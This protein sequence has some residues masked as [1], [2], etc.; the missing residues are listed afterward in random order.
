MSTSMVHAVSIQPT[1]FDRVLIEARIW[2]DDIVPDRYDYYIS[3]GFVTLPA[4]EV[5]ALAP[6]NQ[7]YLVVVDTLPGTGWN[8]PCKLVYVN[9]LM[10]YSDKGQL[11]INT[12]VKDAK[13]PPEGISM[14]P[15]SVKDRYS[16]KLLPMLNIKSGQ[17]NN[18]AS[19]TYAVILNTSP[20]PWANAKQYWNDCSYIYK[21]LEHKYGIPK[22]NIL[23]VMPYGQGVQSLVNNG[24]MANASLDFDADGNDEDIY[25]AT[26]HG[27]D[28]LFTYLPQLGDENH[29]MIFVTGNGGYDYEKGMP[30]LP[31]GNERIYPADL[32]AYLDSVG[33]GYVSIV[34]G[35]SYA[36]GFEKYLKADNR[37][38]ISAAG[39][40]EFAHGSAD[41]PYSEFLYNFTSALNEA[42]GYGNSLDMS[43]ASKAN[44]GARKSL[45]LSFAYAKSASKFL[46]ESTP[47]ISLLKNSTAEDL[48]LD[49]IP[50]VVDLCI[51][52]YPYDDSKKIFRF[53]DPYIWITNESDKLHKGV[54]EKLYVNEGH[55]YV[56]FNNII[57][58]RGVKEYNDESMKIDYCWTTT[59]L[60]IT[61]NQWKGL[62]G[63]S[64][65]NVVGAAL[66][67][68]KTIRDKIKPGDYVFIERKCPIEEDNLWKLEN[69][70]FGMCVLAYLSK[71]LN[72][73]NFPLT[74]D[75][76]A[77][78][79][80]TDKLAQS[81][82]LAYEQSSYL[83]S[84]ADVLLFNSFTTDKTYSIRVNSAS[85]APS[86]LSK[87]EVTLQVSSD[88]AQKWTNS[89][90]AACNVMQDA[91]VVG[92]IR[93]LGK[94]SRM[95]S[96]TLSPMKSDCLKVGVQFNADDAIDEEASYDLNLIAVDNE[97]GN[98]VGGQAIR[99][100]R[101]PRPAI[102][103]A[104]EEETSISASKTLKAVSPSEDVECEWYDSNG[105]LLKKGESYEVPKGSSASE[106]TLKAISKNDGAFVYRTIS[107]ENIPFISD[108]K[109]NSDIITISINR[110]ANRNTTVV[111][112]SP[113]TSIPSKEVRF[114]EGKKVL[115][116]PV[117]SFDNGIL[118][119][120]VAESGKIVE[121]RKI[122]K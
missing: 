6:S 44:V 109:M 63:K 3:D 113:V 98:I 35:Q 89:D 45:S 104:I 96:I 37:I 49:T 99:V 27:M 2:C 40:K 11:S 36:G 71:N 51:T 21:V 25:P 41:V 23:P 12:I 95:P 115:E 53:F 60:F 92:K 97:T 83:T 33:A 52:Q 91:N 119:I 120:S 42:D 103:I 114:T 30:Y 94:N 88:L 5:P 10:T 106:Y 31:L 67:S 74:V 47:D 85:S 77:D 65:P 8:K 111:I 22:S 34:M 16:K 68:S 13:C 105:K 57:R 84:Q 54:T 1:P 90:L 75:N 76:Y 48:A 28:S 101:S 117:G 81:N 72:D 86:L 15:L 59:S 82:V 112:S 102:N 108:I 79:M 20:A 56:F 107:V 24:V 4:S 58:N 26:R 29:L 66:S 118:Q 73:L 46:T 69:K 80:S 116:I 17:T 121:T 9:K 93:L 32:K 61:A 70:D 43:G 122:V 110:P 18:F 38:F 14:S 100:K 87:A 19:K 62:V 78:L 55:D 64:L 39:E 50:D 7:Y